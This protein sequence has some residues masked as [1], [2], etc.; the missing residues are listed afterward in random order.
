MFLTLKVHWIIIF[1]SLCRSSKFLKNTCPSI[2]T[3]ETNACLVVPTPTSH[4]V[5]ISVVR[6]YSEQ[7]TRADWNYGADT[8]LMKKLD[9]VKRTF[10]NRNGARVPF[11]QLPHGTMAETIRS[12]VR[13][14]TGSR[15]AH[16]GTM[17]RHLLRYVCKLL[18]VHVISNL[19]LPR[20][21]VQFLWNRDGSWFQHVFLQDVW[22]IS[23]QR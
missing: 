21:P 20:P 23:A 14:H 22:R 5:C 16:V 18:H 13:L 8:E 6:L 4:I 2:S 7:I 12:L 9:H 11:H 1:M 15:P 19:L 10:S 3:L 17:H